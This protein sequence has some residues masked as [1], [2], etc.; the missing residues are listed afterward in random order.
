VPAGIDPQDHETG[1]N[2]SLENLAR[3][4]E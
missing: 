4:T 1:M 2:S 3:Y